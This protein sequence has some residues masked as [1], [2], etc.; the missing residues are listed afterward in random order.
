MSTVTM[1]VTAAARTAT[2]MP[3]ATARAPAQAGLF[4]GL[5]PSVYNAADPIVLFIIQATIVVALTRLL[6]WP[7][8]KIREPRVIAE[9]IAGII[10]GPSVMGRIPG[11]TAAIFPPAGMAPFRLVANIGLVFFL[12]L[13]GLEI[14]LGYLLS[15]W[16]VAL[17]VASFDMAIP[18]GCGV[19]L[20]YGLYNEF[21]GEP[22]TAPISFG[23]FALFIGVAIAITAFPVLCRILISLKLLNTTV[24]VI[25]LTS[26]IANDVVGWILLALCVTLVNAGAG[27]TALYVLLVAVGY[28][29]V[30]AY[31]VRPAF[32]M[33]LRR[34][35][36]L[37]NGPTEGVVALTIMMVLASS[38]FTSVIGVHSIF[39]AFMIGL[40]CPHEGGFAIKLTEKIEDLTATLFVPLFF[41]LSGI[42]T[43]LGLLDSGVVWGYVIA[44]TVVAFVSKV[45]GGTIGARMNG[46]VWRESFTIGTLM[47]CKGLVE[48]IV[49]NIGLQAKILSTRTFTMFV[50][51]AL[52]TTFA[53]APL[54]SWLYP[55]AY[56]Q[57][58]ELW[59]KG[60][61][62][63]D[64]NPIQHH[65]SEHDSEE[66][67]R[68]GDAATRLM[69]YLRT[70][71]LSS[72]LSL[73]SL[74]TG[75]QSSLPETSDPA[76]LRIHG[77]RLVELTERSSSMMKVSEIEEHAG[78]DPIVKAFGTSTANN[79]ARDVFVSGQVSVVPEGSF[80]DALASQATRG[81]TD[82]LLVPWSETGSL[83]EMPSYF[84]SAKDAPPLLDN[85][86]FRLLAAQIFESARSITAVGVFI[87]KSLFADRSH[88]TG[89]APL[90][91]QL[92]RG[93]A[94]VSL[95]EGH[96][97][98][99]VKFH[100]AGRRGGQKLLRVLHDGGEDD[101]YAVRIA[102]QMAH[103]ETVKLEVVEVIRD[104]IDSEYAVLKSVITEVIGDRVTFTAVPVGKAWGALLA[105][106]E[107]PASS[108]LVVVGR[109]ALLPAT[110]VEIPDEPS[111]STASVMAKVLGPVAEGVIAAQGKREAG[112]LAPSLLVVQAK[113]SAMADEEHLKGQAVGRAVGLGSKALGLGAGV[114]AFLGS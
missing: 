81:N 66:K 30:L 36:S 20:A 65:D 102:F 27:I 97:L 114:G 82:L 37:E 34:T 42:N 72:I 9:V 38:F 5:N 71:G 21:A 83:T 95:A 67:Y 88:E 80:A 90:S 29:L 62:D 73:V 53:T 105:G 19:A 22:G 12:F 15:N 60:R 46:L 92:T 98:N 50:V 41:A 13:V 44:V 28:S 32:M 52:V 101:L 70:D 112:K 76:P 87:D 96:D 89:G 58:L 45:V 23:V 26:G 56:Q 61:I 54:V 109:S 86:A 3:T 100:S 68:Q 74:F 57:K 77:C 24:G 113:Q 93:S 8:A 106:D 18:F 69:V 108:L 4:E 40:I 33:V 51:M 104:G 64:G 110:E 7:L 91:R 25:V 99:A 48:L 14:N 39:G 43:N 10:L 75:G 78:Q 111:T 79:T 107:T 1:T 84:S 55:P 2:A 59:K 94:G 6:Y 16:R 17:G 49:L 35:H 47:S 63:W 31:A 85:P 103:Y 11:F